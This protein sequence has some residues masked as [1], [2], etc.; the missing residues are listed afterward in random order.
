MEFWVFMLITAIL[1]PFAM[2]V[3]GLFFVKRAPKKINF[4]FGYRTERSMKNRDTWEFAHRYFGKLW[5][6]L[7]AIL[8]PI[9]AIPMFFFIG[10]S[11]DLIA[12]ISL[13][14]CFVDMAVM[15]ASV[16]FVEK[17]LKKNFDSDGNKLN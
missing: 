16:V 14:I 10:K 7:G 12:V 6:V 11:E 17:A 2:I 3:S 8:L 9:S 1:C 13:I 5:L 4:F 15:C